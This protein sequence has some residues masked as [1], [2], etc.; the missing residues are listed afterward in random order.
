MHRDVAALRHQ[1]AV[2]IGDGGRQIPRLPQQTATGPSGPG[3]GS[4]PPRRRTGRGGSPPPRTDRD[5]SCGPRQEQIAGLVRP[6]LPAGRHDDGR[7]R[8]LDD[9]RAAHHPV[10]ARRGAGSRFG[11]P[12]HPGKQLHCAMSGGGCRRA[13]RRTWG[14]H[15]GWQPRPHPQRFHHGRFVRRV[16]VKLPVAGVEIPFQHRRVE[17]HGEGDRH[18]VALRRVAHQRGVFQTSPSPPGLT[19]GALA[20]CVNA[21]ICAV[22]SAPLRGPQRQTYRLLAAGTTHRPPGSPEPRTRWTPVAP[23]LSAMPYKLR[24]P[25]G[26]HR[27]AAA[28]GQQRAIP[29]VDPALHRHPAQR[30]RHRRIGHLHDAQSRLH[31]AQAQAQALGDRRHPRRRPRPGRH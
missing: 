10:Q 15:A 28:K 8:I 31:Q 2:G 17:R 27:A 18:R 3:S 29:P 13:P 22:K 24:Q 25:G 5:C 9:R 16:A 21:S 7:P 1:F 14:W 23:P 30:P 4:S 20:A 26:M 6:R 11:F 12:T 19:N